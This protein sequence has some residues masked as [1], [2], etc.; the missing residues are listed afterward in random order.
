MSDRRPATG[1]PLPDDCFAHDL[2]LIPVRTAFDI[3]K[4][5]ISAVV[6]VNSVP[7]GHA[8]GRVLSQP[9]VASRNI[10]AF[11]NAAV[12]GYA[13]ARSDLKSEEA[14]RLKVTMRVTAGGARPSALP[15]QAAAQVFT[16]AP[17]PERADSVV[18]QEDVTVEG[19][20]VIIPSGIKRGI[21][22]RLAGEDVISGETVLHPGTIIGPREI[23]LIA[24]L[25]LSEVPVFSPLRV[26]LMSTGDEIHDPGNPLSESGVYDANRHMLRALLSPSRFNVDD[27]GIVRDDAE[28]VAE[29]LEAAAHRHDVIVTSGGASMGEEDHVISAVRRLG[30]LH[31][32]RIAVKPGRPLAFGRIGDATFIGLPGNPVAAMICFVMIARPV[33]SVLGGAAWSEPPRY[34]LPSSFDFKKKPGRREWLRGYLEQDADG[35]ISVQR[36]SRQGS[37]ILSGL[38]EADGLV[39]LSEDLTELRSG[40]TISFIPFDSLDVS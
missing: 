6:S 40:D 34:P 8:N 18:M 20:N 12:D 23:G 24:A 39:E 25:G 22:R 11:D 13:V 10:P 17:I 21:N 32:W 28:R 30:Q 1:T 15:W 16:G 26:A 29:T 27:L 9:V 4:D 35:R 2:E 19:E 33:L 14:T 36:I 37:G 7:L 38:R 3:L 31:I 5:R